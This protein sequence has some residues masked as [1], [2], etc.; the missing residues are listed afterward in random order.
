MKIVLISIFL[1]IFQSIHAQSLVQKL[2]EFSSVDWERLVIYASGRSSQLTRSSNGSERI[3]AL[4]S[5][6]KAAV[7]RLFR[8]VQALRIDANSTIKTALNEKQFSALVLRNIVEGFTIVDTRSMSDMS[9]ELDIE[10]P[11][12][13]DLSSLLLPKEMGGDQ[14]R[15]SSQPLCPTCFEAWPE[16]REVPAGVS[17]IIPSEGFSA[18]KG[19][20]YTGLIIDARGLDLQQAIMPKVLN[21]HQ[22]EIYGPGYANYQVALQSGIVLYKKDL[23]SALKDKRVGPEPLI[24]RGV[25]AFGKLKTNLIISHTDALLIHAAVK[26]QNF[27]KECKVIIVT[28]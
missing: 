13:G 11:L 7:E 9:V 8:A 10:F 26:R 22:E 20:P 25:G 23:A 24:V 21:G 16:N 1:F 4:E 28:G 19:I 18:K 5:A 12:T 3:A 15:L 17:L 27:L 6:K 14:L 2:D